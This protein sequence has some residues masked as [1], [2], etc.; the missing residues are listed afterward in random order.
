MSIRTTF[1]GLGEHFRFPNL[2]HLKIS[3]HKNGTYGRA[4]DA[5]EMVYMRYPFCA[6]FIENLLQF[7]SPFL[8]SLTLDKIPMRIAQVLAILAPL[9]SLTRLVIT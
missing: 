2:L 4:R 5:A 1:V 8:S 9:T 7:S 3:Y 6:S